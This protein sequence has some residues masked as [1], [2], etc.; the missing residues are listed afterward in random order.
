MARIVSCS[1]RIASIS[2]PDNVPIAIATA[3]FVGAGIIIVFVV[4]LLWAQR[5]LRTL[6]PTIGW[7]RAT[8]VV[9]D[10]LLLLMFFTFLNNIITTVQTFYTL[11]P[12]TLFIDRALLLF[13]STFLAIVSTLPILFVLLALALP[14][15][16][17]SEKFGA[18]KLS[19]K[20]AVLLAGS[21][22][23]ALGA[24]YRCGTSWVKPVPIT[25]PLPGYFAKPCFYIFNFGVEILTLY[26]YAFAR[27]DLLFHVPDGAK[28]PGS[29]EAR[30]E[31]KLVNDDRN[32]TTSL[33]TLEATYSP[34]LMTMVAG[35]HDKDTTREI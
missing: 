15:R 5:I 13:G 24:W 25:K 29:Y 2:I 11:R 35:T 6:H 20:I 28:G 17:Q 1:L 14:R 3:I 23:V 18:G 9:F 4:N 27:V 32:D 19:T 7:H 16:S 26:L 21:A 10:V 31:A 8:S 34:P 12:R 22:L 33:R 30:D